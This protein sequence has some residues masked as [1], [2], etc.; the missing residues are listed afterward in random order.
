M[1]SNIPDNPVSDAFGWLV[2]LGME[3]DE[4]PFL[5]PC[6]PGEFTMADTF[7]VNSA[8]PGIVY[9]GTQ[10]GTLPLV[11]GRWYIIPEDVIERHADLSRDTVAVAGAVRRIR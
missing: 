8:S 10:E 11:A 9:R 7:Y 2:E 3:R 4:L 1:N 6:V 5:N